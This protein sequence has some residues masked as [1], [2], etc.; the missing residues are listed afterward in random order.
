M[1]QHLHMY[2]W[3]RINNTSSESHQRPGHK[4]FIK[5]Q[6]CFALVM[7]EWTRERWRIT[8]IHRS[9]EHTNEFWLMINSVFLWEV[10]LIWC[11]FDACGNFLQILN[12]SRRSSCSNIMSVLS[13]H[14]VYMLLL[15]TCFHKVSACRLQTVML[16]EVSMAVWGGNHLLC[17]WKKSRILTKATFIW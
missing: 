2:D 10:C 13:L 4:G 8:A 5:V 7:N 15:E 16:W 14:N 9:W 11:T 17:F 3:E 12:F 1:H 6:Y